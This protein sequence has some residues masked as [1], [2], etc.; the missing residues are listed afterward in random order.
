MLSSLGAGVSESINYRGWCFDSRPPL[1]ISSLSRAVNCS[2]YVYVV[3]KNVSSF[4][5]K[6]LLNA[7][8]YNVKDTV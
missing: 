2:H 3:A 5:E 8:E 7:A 6:N 4:G 1:H